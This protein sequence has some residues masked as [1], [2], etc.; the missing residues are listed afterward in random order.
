MYEYDMKGEGERILLPD[1]WHLFQV[2]DMQLGKSKAGN[3][4][5]IVTLDHPE[6]GAAEDVY[7]ITAKGKR[8]K[9]KGFLKACGVQ[10]DEQGKFKFEPQDLVGLTV[11]GCNKQEPNE[12][13]NREGEVIK[14]MRNNLTKFRATLEKATL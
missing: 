10:E 8:W 6:T 7:M 12:Y 2:A 14:E 5:F 13:T 4:M 9:L 11:E 1:G 3:D